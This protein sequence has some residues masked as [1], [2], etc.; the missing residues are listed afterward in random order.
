MPVLLILSLSMALASITLRILILHDSFYTFLCASIVLCA[1]PPSCQPLHILE[2]YFSHTFYGYVCILFNCSVRRTSGLSICVR[3]PGCLHIGSSGLTRL[4]HPIDVCW[5]SGL[6]ISV[7]SVHRILRA[8]RLTLMH[9]AY[10]YKL[11]LLLFI[12]Q[13]FHHFRSS[14]HQIFSSISS[15]TF[16]AFSLSLQF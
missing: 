1:G 9:T 15:F 11:S 2:A 13:I 5:T 7:P 12:T 14:A 4:I 16:I 8:A 3:P 10:C 6:S